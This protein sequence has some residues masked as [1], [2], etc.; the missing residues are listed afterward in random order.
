VL[1]L[2][3]RFA[4]RSNIITYPPGASVGAFVS[5]LTEAIQGL[6]DF[7]QTAAAAMDFRSPVYGSESA[8]SVLASAPDSEIDSE[9][10]ELTC[11]TCWLHFDTADVM[12]I[13]THASLRGDSKLGE[14]AMQRFVPSRFN[15][16]GIA[17]DAMGI[18]S[19]EMSCPHCHRK[20]PT[21]FLDDEHHIFS[22]VGAPTSGKSYYLAILIRELQTTLYRH[23]EIA[24]RDADPSLNANLNL[25]KNRLSSG[26]SPAEVALDKTGLEGAMYELLPRYGQKVMLPKP[27][28][29]R[30]SN[31]SNSS[32]GEMSVIFYDN[33]GE[34]FEPG[35]SSADSPGAQHVASA[36]T[37]FFLFDPLNSNA[38]RQSLEG[39]TDPGANSV[40]L[41]QQDVILAETETRM[42]SLL[43][44]GRGERVATPFAFIVGKGDALGHLISPGEIEPIVVDGQIDQD[45]VDRNSARVRAMLLE[46]HSAVV[47]NAEA[48]SSDVRY[49][50]ISA[51]GSAPVRFK[52][53]DGS[54][55]IG[56][57]PKRIRPQFIE[58]PTLWAL[59]RVAPHIVTSR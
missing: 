56:P 33:A 7:S 26:A 47:A 45:A 29:F 53:A 46:Y 58:H 25:M 5:H 57:D 2:Y 6:T 28:I 54:S 23:F 1:P 32:E 12:N 11:P 51:F 30:L 39:T 27:F 3:E 52:A 9:H 24:F 8:D 50:L 16:S 37:I 43:G 4:D 21:G 10:G 22:I 34:H 55:K 19:P 44:L 31:Q 59:S 36:S 40:A 20:L 18:P 13:A 42:K 48:I 14:D 15:D 38:F 17:L 35:R 49:F 41:D